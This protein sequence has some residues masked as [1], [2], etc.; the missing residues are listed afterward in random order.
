MQMQFFLLLNKTRSQQFPSKQSI[1]QRT[2]K[3]VWVNLV[4]DKDPS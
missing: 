2:W 1:I 3:T 4:K